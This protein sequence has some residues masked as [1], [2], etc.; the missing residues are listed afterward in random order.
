MLMSETIISSVNKNA[1]SYKY[2]E[3]H[4]SRS[5]KS[6]N[7]FVF[8]RKRILFIFEGKNSISAALEEV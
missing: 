7:V 8:F 4:G 6:L 5:Q 3:S 1:M 2:T